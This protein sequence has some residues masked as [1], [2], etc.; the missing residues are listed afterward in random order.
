[1]TKFIELTEERVNGFTH[2][3]PIKKSYNTYF[4]KDS[5]VESGK[6]LL[7]MKGKAIKD[8]RLVSETNAHVLAVANAFIPDSGEEVLSLSVLYKQGD[9]PTAIIAYVKNFAKKSIVEYYAD[10]TT[11]TITQIVIAKDELTAEREI[12][13]VD[14]DYSV[15]STSIAPEIG[16]VG[17][18]TVTAVHSGDE[19]DITTTLTLTNFIIGAPGAA[20]AAK[21]IGNIVYAFPAGQHFELVNSLSSLV[22]K[23]AGTSVA[24]D[25]GLGSV[26]ASGV[27]SVLSG[28]ATFEDRLTGQTINTAAAGGAAVSA[29]TATTAGI[30]T[31][32]SL[33]IAA[34]IKN[35]FLNSAGTWNANNVGNLT[36]SG[37]IVLKWTRM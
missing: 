12:Y 7:M 17:A 35:V 22:L 25:T 27:V 32:I 36:A 9:T 23:A 6:A 2:A 4:L 31:G 16:T 19:K 34:S 28:T 13:F 10:P 21:G 3:T 29:L 37:T 5:V 8:T 33:N 20:A 24:T 30:G 1:M 11:A 14:E 18:S 15:I 26:V